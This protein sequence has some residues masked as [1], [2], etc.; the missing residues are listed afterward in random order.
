M[1]LNV[2]K[3]VPQKVSCEVHSIRSFAAMPSECYLANQLEGEDQ[4]RMTNVGTTLVK[5]GAHGHYVQC[6]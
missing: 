1:H 3:S 5:G 6:L 4:V 2:P